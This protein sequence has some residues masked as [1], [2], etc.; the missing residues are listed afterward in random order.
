MM[1]RQASTCCVTECHVSAV[2]TISL[3]TNATT[4]D[5]TSIEWVKKFYSTGTSDR[6]LLSKSCPHDLY[7]A[8]RPTPVRVRRFEDTLAPDSKRHQ[9]GIPFEHNTTSKTIEPT[10]MSSGQYHSETTDSSCTSQLRR[11]ESCQ[12]R[13]VA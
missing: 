9:L 6:P 2:K 1:L 10:R 13:S 3:Q 4:T 7:M 8:K 5:I 12:A 11:S